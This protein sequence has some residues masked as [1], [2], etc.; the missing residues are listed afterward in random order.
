MLSMESK[1]RSET[2]LTAISPLPE[3][4]PQSQTENSHYNGYDLLDLINK[5]KIPFMEASV[6]KYTWRHQ[7]KG[8]A[9][10]ID[11]AIDYLKKIKAHYYPD[12]PSQ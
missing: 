10:D 8:G 2:L 9:K 3:A 1:R 6:M 7:K 4:N 11:K 5:H 12:A